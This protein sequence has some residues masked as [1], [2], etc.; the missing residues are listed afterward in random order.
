[1]LLGLGS[2]SYQVAS[3]EGEPAGGGIF[4]SPKSE[5]GGG[6]TAFASLFE[7]SLGPLFQILQRQKVAASGGFWWEGIET[8]GSLGFSAFPAYHHLTLRNRT[9]SQRYH[10]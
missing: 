6:L 4:P 5:D 3:H 7:A 8:P 1:M 10:A 9:K 2:D